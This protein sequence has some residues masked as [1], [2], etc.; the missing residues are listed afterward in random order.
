MRAL[1]GMVDALAPAHWWM[2][3]FEHGPYEP[4]EF[5]LDTRESGTPATIDLI[6]PGHPTDRRQQFAASLERLA[7][8]P[9]R[10]VVTCVPAPGH[11]HDITV[12]LPGLAASDSLRSWQRISTRPLRGRFARASASI[13]SDVS[14]ATR[15]WISG[16]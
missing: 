7:A 9:G 1:F 12:G 10:K 5:E 3:G 2:I 16:W 8:A 4:M 11:E 15:V 6:G 14:T 13:G